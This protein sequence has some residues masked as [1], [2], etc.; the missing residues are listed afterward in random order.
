[1][2]EMLFIG[3]FVAGA[4]Y[5]VFFLI[6]STIKEEKD[7][8]LDVYRYLSRRYNKTVVVD[9]GGLSSDPIIQSRDAG[10]FKLIEVKVV[11]EKGGKTTDQDLILRGEVDP[12]KFKKGEKSANL[13]LSPQLRWKKLAH[14]IVIGIPRLDDRFI[15]SSDDPFF[16]RFILTTDLGDLIQKSFDLEEYF[17]RWMGDSPIVQVRMET[18]SSNSFIQAFNILL[19]TIGALS[20][21][22]YLSRTGVKKK[23]REFHIPSPS[24]EEKKPLSIPFESVQLQVEKKLEITKSGEETS[25][26]ETPVIGWESL[27]E[28]SL[29]LEKPIEK[30]SIESPYKSLFTS[31]Q[32]QAKKIEYERDRVRILT[33]SRASEEIFVTF[34]QENKAHFTTL[35]DRS[36]P[37]EFELQI[38]Y[39]GQARQTDWSNAWKDIKI[40]G[41]PDIIEKLQIRTGIAHRIANTGEIR[42]IVRGHPD[43]KLEC[44]L[45]VVKT[46][47]G[48]NAGYSL[49]KD[50]IWF[51]EMI[52]M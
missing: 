14:D 28:D 5:V 43:K 1:M 30:E 42:A 48:I 18:M 16:P 29:M 44:E 31:I 4:I 26:P 35:V 19:G 15:I 11:T 50:I 46:I 10:P 49:L 21:K 37:A 38:E 8:S 2:F 34:P 7:F 33:F 17:I 20:E 47:R 9:Y 40:V 39:Q 12:Q 41:P 45:T 32:Y 52:F 51:F 25:K 6:Y 23:K 24:H 3:L 22:G 36:P 27:P 13:S